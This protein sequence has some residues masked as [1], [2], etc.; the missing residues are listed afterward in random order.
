MRRADAA[1][2]AGAAA[3]LDA[4]P[5]GDG[6]SNNGGGC[7]RAALLTSAWDSA[8]RAAAL[9]SEETSGS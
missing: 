3:E 9:C 2:P 1:A 5:P 6:D 7:G 4:L 8:R